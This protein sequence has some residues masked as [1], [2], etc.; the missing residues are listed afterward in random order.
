MSC[1][2]LS[3]FFVK[4]KKFLMIVIVRILYIG[5]GI[6]RNIGWGC[7]ILFLKLLLC[8]RFKFVIFVILFLIGLKI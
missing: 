7:G 4:L 5:G 6:F 1:Y 3:I 8:L 2:I